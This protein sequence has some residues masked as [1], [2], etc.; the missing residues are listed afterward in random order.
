MVE[1]RLKTAWSV[2]YRIFRPIT[3]RMAL[4]RLTEQAMGVYL[5]S[6]PEGGFVGRA[7]A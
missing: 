1:F 7:Y 5:R 6:I 2:L 3:A 4:S